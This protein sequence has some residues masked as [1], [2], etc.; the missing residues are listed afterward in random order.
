VHSANEVDNPAILSPDL[1]ELGHGR[2]YL[3]P[4]ELPGD[5]DHCDSWGG[6]IAAGEDKFTL[7]KLSLLHHDNMPRDPS[8]QREFIPYGRL[9]GRLKR[10]TEPGLRLSP[11]T[12]SDCGLSA[13][14]AFKIK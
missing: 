6:G 1:V 10:P 11:S 8:T 9:F 5:F 12:S 4:S 14:A 3:E 2:S 7:I 13:S